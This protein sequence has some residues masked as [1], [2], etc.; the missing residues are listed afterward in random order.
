MQDARCKTVV[1]VKVETLVTDNRLFYCLECGKCT[2]VCPM[3][4]LFEDFSYDVS[5]RGIVEKALLD[6]DL[7]N[8]GSIWFCLTCDVCTDGCPSGV[9]LKDFIKSL[10]LLAMEEGIR[11]AGLFCKRC[12][13]YFLP[14]H[15]LDYLRETLGD[16]KAPLDWLNLC[17][18]CRKY[19]FGEV[20]KDNLRGS[21]RVG[22]MPDARS[23]M[24]ERRG[25]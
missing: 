23:Q 25:L 20:V 10:R 15:T 11:E 17:H 2:S 21:R 22:K 12:G 5:P 3:G 14:T 13:K 18:R 19:S 6:L 1:S 16:E 9:R 4:D 24:P 7:V 8:D